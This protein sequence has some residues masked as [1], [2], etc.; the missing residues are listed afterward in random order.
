M[1]ETIRLLLAEDHEVV[2]EA[3]RSLL[4]AHA[5][6]TVVGEAGN[7][8]ELLTLAEKSAPDVVVMDINMPELNGIEATR[9]LTA[10][11]PHIKIIGLSVHV[12]GRIISEM[13]KA[14]AR[15]YIPKTSASSEL[16][17]AIH[18]VMAGKMYVSADVMAELV[19]TRLSVSGEEAQDAFVKL[20]E[21]EREV[22]QLLAEGNT[23][24]EIAAKLHLS[25]PTVHT[26]RQHIMQK[27]NTRSIAD[28]IRY[29][30][31]EGIASAGI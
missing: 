19:K 28:L 17:E 9:Q 24:K 12:T 21:R 31:R 30:I 14:G 11:L 1:K 15:G 13:L 27:L 8:R 3:L 5:G 20:S 10:R 26:H 25:V 22:L 7:G 4:T 23:T 2:R 18:A 6:F 29:A 16:L